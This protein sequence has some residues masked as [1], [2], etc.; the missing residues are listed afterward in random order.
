[1]GKHFIRFLE[2]NFVNFSLVQS[3]HVSVD[4]ALVYTCNINFISV[5]IFYCAQPLVFLFTAF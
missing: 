3:S 2:E 5:Y 4:V 1:M